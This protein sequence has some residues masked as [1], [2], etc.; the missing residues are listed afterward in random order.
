MDTTTTD[1][2]SRSTG[3]GRDGLLSPPGGW[4]AAIAVLAVCGIASH[5]ILWWNGFD[6]RWWG[7]TIHDWPLIIALGL[8]GVPLVLEL[9][10]DLLRGIFGSDLLAAISIATSGLLEEYLAGVIVVLMLAGGQWLERFAFMESAGDR[11]WPI[12][13]ASYVVSAVKR[14][15][16]M[17]LI[18]PVWKRKSRR[19]SARQ[20]AAVA[21]QASQS[22][23]LVP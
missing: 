20:A 6:T 1:H 16:G 13:G 7:L 17:R 18:T 14:V 3:S 5:L 21:S 12:F 10:R 22:N 2:P 15:A 9:L 4:H 8:G 11:W 23:T 19:R